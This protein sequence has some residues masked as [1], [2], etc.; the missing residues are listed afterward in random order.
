MKTP[1]IHIRRIPYEEPDNTQLEFR[2]SNGT[3]AG[4]VYMYCNVDDLAEMATSLKSF[5]A[6]SV[7]EY[8]YEYGRDEPGDRMYRYFKLRFYTTDHAGHCAVQFS[9]NLRED[10]PEEGICVFSFRVEPAA[11]HRFGQ[12]LENFHKLQHLELQWS[13]T[14]GALFEDYQDEFE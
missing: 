10:A 11:I 8:A 7:D 13:P 6:Q 3:F 2:A 4:V 9:V 1:Y 14:G 5:P 12:L